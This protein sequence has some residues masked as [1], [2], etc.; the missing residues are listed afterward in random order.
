MSSH[1][2][3]ISLFSP[4][5]GGHIWVN[6]LK[7]RAPIYAYTEHVQFGEVSWFELCQRTV[8]WC[9]SFLEGRGM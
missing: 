7:L 9:S 1:T 2:E 8:A 5:G 4:A 3:V 6:Q